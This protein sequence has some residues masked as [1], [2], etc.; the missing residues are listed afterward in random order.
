M[1]ATDEAEKRADILAVVEML[2]RLSPVQVDV[3]RAIVHRFAKEQFGELLRNDFLN[4]DAYEYFSMRLAAHHAY[5]ASVLKK[6]NFEHI[7]E[8]AFSRTGVPAQRA[9]SM[10]VR[11]ADLTVGGVTLSLKTEAARNLSQSHITISK[12]MEAA[13]IKQT[14][15]TDDIP[16]FIGQMVMPHFRNYER[17]FTLRSYPDSERNGFVRYDLREIP[18]DVLAR[19]GDLT[20]NDFAAPTKTRT[21]SADVTVNGRRAFRFRLDGSD[22]KLTIN[23]LDVDFCPLHAWWSLCAPGLDRQGELAADDV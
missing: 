14:T 13:W 4:R 8:E 3:V 19:I 21:T 12:L 2:Q 7:L 16:M 11:G 9:H 18:K 15:C 23:Y 17:I 10:T 1:A 20:G 6:E 5:S 22:D